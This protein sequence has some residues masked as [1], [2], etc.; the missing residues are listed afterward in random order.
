[1]I[2]K[3]YQVALKKTTNQSHV[4]DCPGKNL[5]I[6]A[7]CNKQHIKNNNTFRSDH[8]GKAEMITRNE[9]I[10]ESNMVY[11]YRYKDHILNGRKRHLTKFH[12][13]SY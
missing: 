4:A 6:L 12:T 10:H 1:M 2:L 7:N 11:S 9:E 5:K 8:S 13:L 3:I